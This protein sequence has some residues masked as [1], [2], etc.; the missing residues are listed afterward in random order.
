MLTRQE[1]EQQLMLCKLACE[2]GAVTTHQ[3]GRFT[4]RVTY[5]RY[6]FRVERL[7]PD[8]NVGVLSY[9][10]SDFKNNVFNFQGHLIT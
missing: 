4:K 9:F 7:D 10:P 1:Y 6:T 5:P 3:P 8:T 2:A